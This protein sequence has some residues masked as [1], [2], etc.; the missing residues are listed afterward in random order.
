MNDTAPSSAQSTVGGRLA[1]RLVAFVAIAL[2]MPVV[3]H[4]SEPSKGSALLAPFK[5]ELKAAL[6]AGLARGPI[7][8]IDACR[9]E[10]PEI[11]KRLSHDGVR[12]GRASRRLRNPA[13]AAPEWVLP[14]LEA[15]AEDDADR[16]PRTITLSDERSGYAEPILVQPLCLTCHGPS[17]APALAARIE[18]LYPDDRATGYAAGDLRGVF[19]VEY[20]RAA[21]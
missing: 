13:N 2:T 7:E 12:V 9:V 14:I 3:T 19:W 5:R 11:S 15:Y 8:A 20:P 6:Q 4:A 16:T 18:T 10:A 1:G 21:E 17:L